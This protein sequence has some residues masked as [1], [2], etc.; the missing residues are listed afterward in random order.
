VLTQHLELALDI[1]S[2]IESVCVA[3]RIQVSSAWMVCLLLYLP[4][5]K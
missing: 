1:Y 2:R 3:I 4:A 5:Q